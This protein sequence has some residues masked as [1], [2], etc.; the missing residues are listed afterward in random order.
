MAEYLSPGIF[1]EEFDSGAVPMS[2]VSTSTAGFIGVTE[3]GPQEGAPVLIT[4]FSDYYRTFGG[5]ISESEFGEYRYLPYA[6][7]QFF[8]NGGSRCFIKRVTPS[9]ATFAHFGQ[10]EDSLLIYA[11]NPGSWGNKISLT[12]IP[13]S[14]SKTQILEEIT[15]DLKIKYRV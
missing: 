2:S 15:Q 8:T 1:V 10:K 14:K 13:T 9:D 4:S 3:K 5:Y 6:V 7:N 12:M 11:K